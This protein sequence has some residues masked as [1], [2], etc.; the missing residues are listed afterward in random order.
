VDAP[1]HGTPARSGR[2]ALAV[3]AAA[4]LAAGI[5]ATAAPAGAATQPPVAPAAA[6]PTAPCTDQAVA[7]CLLPYP[8]ARWIV[9]DASTATGVRIDV[10][11]DVLPARILD[12]F[13]PG[14]TVADAFGGADGFSPLTPIIFELTA[15]VDPATLPADGG[16]AL[17][18][19]DVTAGTRVPVR[20]EVSSDANRL[21]AGDRIVWA[22]PATRFAY[23][24]RIVAVVTDVLRG[25]GGAAITPA[26]GLSTDPSAAAAA[27]SAQLRGDLEAVAPATTWDSLLSATEFV[28]RSQANI[29][30]DLDAMAAVVRSQDHPIRDVHLGPSLIGGAAAVTGQV[31]VTDFRDDDGVIRRGAAATARPHWI[32]FL[33]TLPSTP[34]GPAG[35]PV[36]IYGHGITASKETMAVVASTN[37]TRGMATVGI[38]VPNHGSR[39]WEGGWILDLAHPRSIGRLTSLPLQGELDELS[40]LMAVRQHFGD[41]DLLP[42]DLLS[43]RSGDGMAD[44]DPSRVLYE[45]T[46]MGGFLG[47]SFTA[48]A[49][50]LDGA[51]LQVAGSG[52]LDTLAHSL[53]WPLFTS[54]EPSGA[55]A[56]DTEA[57]LGVVSMLLDPADN[58]YVLDRIVAERTPLWLE[59]AANDGVVPNTSSDRMLSLLGLPI[60]GPT[61]APVPAGLPRV[62][63]LP[64]SGSGATQAPT[65]YLD[66]NWAKPLLTHVTF[67]DPI[68]MAALDAWLDQRLESTGAASP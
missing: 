22:W 45:G 18:V 12:Q 49:P 56:G 14:G 35:A 51:F 31:Q 68:P 17:A 8:S 25:R 21:G 33:M 65:D 61:T 44:L 5:L 52:I 1:K 67:V 24:H 29:T 16:D 13:G 50:E 41:L 46:S 54:V 66:G 36:V 30:D 38:D 39:Q 27:R 20:A 10:P 32:D 11:A 7:S 6:A 2:A 28:V 4:V 53:I 26:R 15:P 34:A 42:F 55:S 40:L 62:S 59:Y 57:L 37:A 48:L 23:G 43:G 47:A 19:Y 63:A 9:P 64:P 58:T 3:I 60:D